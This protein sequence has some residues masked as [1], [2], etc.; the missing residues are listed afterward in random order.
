M[1]VVVFG[2]FLICY[3]PYVVINAMQRLTPV[4]VPNNVNNACLMLVLLNSLLNVPIYL[5]LNAEF[6]VAF[7]RLCRRGQVE[8]RQGSSME[9]ASWTISG[10]RT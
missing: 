1:F 10:R 3:T 5:A 2:V 8:S 7:T 4:P 9:L 6:R